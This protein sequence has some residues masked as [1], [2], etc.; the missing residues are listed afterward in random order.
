MKYISLKEQA[1]K[2]LV[3]EI[4]TLISSIQEKNGFAYSLPNKK[5]IN[6]LHD[7]SKRRTVTSSNKIEGIQVSKKREEELLI[8]KADAKTKED[9][10]LLGYNDALTYIMDNYQYLSLDERLIKDLHYLM[11]KRYSPDFGGKYKIDQ[12]YISSYDSKGN[13]LTNVFT[14]PSPREAPQLMG[15]LV[16]QFNNACNEPLSNKLILIFLFILDFLCI[17]PFTDGNGRVSRLLTTFLLLRYGYS[18]D[19]YYSIS[20]LILEHLDDYYKTLHLSSTGWHENDNN[21]FHFVHYHLLRLVEGY[22][23]LEYIIEVNDIKDSAENLVLK[24]IDDHRI[25]TSKEYIEEILYKYT[26]TTIEKSLK[27]LLDKNKIELAS[28]GRVAKYI[29]KR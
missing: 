18:L 26:R 24:I 4:L 1:E 27:D 5:K 10:E 6:R 28:K 21:P 3:P 14:P 15:N 22:Q 11:Y 13:F 7:L 20:Y 2:L 25:P 12:N 19:K 8:D 16:W 17:H 23:N 29:V 9:Y